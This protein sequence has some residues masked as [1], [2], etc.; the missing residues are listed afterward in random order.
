[1]L[2]LEIVTATGRIKMGKNDY[3]EFERPLVNTGEQLV[4]IATQDLSYE[5][6]DRIR[7]TLTDPGQFL[8]L[9]LDET[10]DSSLVYITETTYEFVVSRAAVEAHVDHRFHN[11]RHYLSA[12]IAAIEEVAGYRNWALNPHDQ[13]DAHGC[14][15][16]AFA[17]VETRN[18]A[19]FF[20]SNAIDGVYAN[21]NHGSY[22]YQSWGINQQED[23]A[24][25]IDFGREVVLDKVGL[26]LLGDYPHDSHWVSCTL[27]FSD[28]SKEVLR[29]TDSLEVQYFSF[30]KRTTTRVVFSDLIKA[31]DESPFPALTEIELWGWNKE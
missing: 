4:Y 10:L 15:P 1:M 31:E 12:R 2:K 29:T 20:A 17:N 25:T 7:L 3:E 19:T 6:G 8:W 14:Y 22:P 11:K 24:L 26:M 18:D 23:A 9:R 16:H 5:E 28:G 13:K 21:T 30:A 27:T